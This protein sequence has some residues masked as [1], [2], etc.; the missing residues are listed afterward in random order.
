MSPHS[1]HYLL[2][3]ISACIEFIHTVW[4]TRLGCFHVTAIWVQAEIEVD[5]EVKLSWGEVELRLRLIWSLVEV[6][7]RLSW[8]WIEGKKGL[9]RFKVLFKNIFRFTHITEQHVPLNSDLY[10]HPMLFFSFVDHNGLF[11]EVG[12]ETQKF[13][14]CIYLFIFYV[15][16]NYDFLF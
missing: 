10:F 9:F 16:V 5:F 12:G 6:E 2:S 15:S 13:C 11:L 4:Y 7:L 14:D 8:G 1:K 3:G